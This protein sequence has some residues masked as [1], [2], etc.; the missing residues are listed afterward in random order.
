MIEATAAV[1]DAAA[2]LHN[3]LQGVLEPGG[4]T[5][6]TAS[7]VPGG[8]GGVRSSAGSPEGSTGQRDASSAAKAG[9]RDTRIQ[10]PN[11]LRCVTLHFL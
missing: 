8:H 4:T 11:E 7:A 10:A 9:D 2:A 6:S 5:A 3:R 1:D